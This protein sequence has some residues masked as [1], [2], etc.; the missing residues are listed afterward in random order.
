VNSV[1]EEDGNC[2]VYIDRDGN[3]VNVGGSCKQ[4]ATAAASTHAELLSFSKCCHIPAGLTAQF[5]WC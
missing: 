1:D 3:I 4:A 5:T 2:P